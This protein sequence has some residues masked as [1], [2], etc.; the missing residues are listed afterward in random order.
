MKGPLL[1]K[2]FPQLTTLS[3]GHTVIKLPDSQYGLFFSR[4]LTGRKE[5]QVIEKWA[6][7]SFQY[8]CN[9]LKN[10]FPAESSAFTPNKLLMKKLNPVDKHA[11]TPKKTE[12]RIARMYKIQYR[13]LHLKHDLAGKCFGKCT[14]GTRHLSGDTT[15]R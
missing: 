13:V 4:S 10:R 9:A 14:A 6:K 5:K 15:A 11:F 12:Q 7:T 2:N 3:N 1:L 8:C